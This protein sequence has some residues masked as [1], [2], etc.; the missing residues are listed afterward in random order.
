MDWNHFADINTND[1]QI[2]FVDDVQPTFLNSDADETSA[3]GHETQSLDLCSLEENMKFICSVSNFIAMVFTTGL[4]R[5]TVKLYNVL[6]VLFKAYTTEISLVTFKTVQKKIWSYMKINCLPV[7]KVVDLRHPN[8]LVDETKP[9]NPHHTVCIINPSEWV[10]MDLKMTEYHN[11]LINNQPKESGPD[12]FNAKIFTNRKDMNCLNRIMFVSDDNTKVIARPGDKIRIPV[13]S[14]AIPLSSCNWFIDN[15]DNGPN[16][17]QIKK[18]VQVEAE[19][20]PIW[21]VNTGLSTSQ[22]TH[23]IKNSQLTSSITENEHSL[24]NIVNSG[25]VLL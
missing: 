9:F 18:C 10:K 19:I 24:L 21:I 6:R 13:T 7:S 1:N 14:D 3:I 2:T 17:T 22:R 16:G 25:K 8:R 11:Q 4:H 15:I 20:G 12:I 5:C 23:D